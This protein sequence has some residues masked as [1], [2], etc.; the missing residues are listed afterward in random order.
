MA[1][2]SKLVQRLNFYYLRINESHISTSQIDLIETLFPNV[3][4]ALVSC[5]FEMAHHRVPF[6][7][8]TA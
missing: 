4:S 7:E 3:S 5:M 2:Y 6:R 8:N 1:F